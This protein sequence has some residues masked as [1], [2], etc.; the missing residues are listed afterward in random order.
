MK[1]TILAL[2]TLLLLGYSSAF[3]QT[4]YS[5]GFL[6]YDQKTQ[7]CDYEVLTVNP[8]YAAGT[9]EIAKPCHVGNNGLMVGVE[10]NIS[11]GPPITGTVYALADSSYDAYYYSANGY[12]FLWLTTLQAATPEQLETGGPFGWAFYYTIGDGV[13]YLGN[14]GFLTTHLG[15]RGE[16][17]TTFYNI[18]R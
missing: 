3:A 10:A 12:P 14:Y 18:V 9:H 5:F 4:T 8:P 15:G 13:E 11:A 17:K 6:S 16:S 7:Y 2:V 1:L